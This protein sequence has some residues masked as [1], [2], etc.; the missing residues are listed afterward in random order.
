MVFGCRVKGVPSQL[1][2]ITATGEAGCERVDHTYPKAVAQ[3][4]LGSMEALGH[5][6]GVVKRNLRLGLSGSQALGHPGAA[7]KS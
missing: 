5:R 7:R 2:P 6:S 3:W 1:C 4:V